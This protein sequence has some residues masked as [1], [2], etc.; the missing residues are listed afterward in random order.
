MYYELI[1]VTSEILASKYGIAK[2]QTLPSW[3]FTAFLSFITAKG[4]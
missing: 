1:L 3:F 2:G 4:V